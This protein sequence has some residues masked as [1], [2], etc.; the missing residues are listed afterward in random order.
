MKF[1]PSVQTS[2]ISRIEL[3]ELVCEVWRELG[4]GEGGSSVF[5]TCTGASSEG[6]GGEGGRGD[7]SGLG[8]RD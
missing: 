6:G 4:G 3:G 5:S 1:P 7:T 8:V 2:R